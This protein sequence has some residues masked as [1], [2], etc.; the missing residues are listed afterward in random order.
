[1]NDKDQTSYEIITAAVH[2]RRPPRLPVQMASL[3]VADNAFLWQPMAMS[4]A[5]GAG[6]AFEP[7]APKADAWGCVWSQTEL[8]NMGQVTGHP[9]ERGVP[10]NL[11]GTP[12][13][14]YNR[15]I[16]YQDMEAPIARAEQAGKYIQAG[17]F[18]V[19]F[20]R[21]HSM[22]GFE[23]AML[24]LG[25]PDSR[26]D[27]QRLAAF[28]ADQH[29]IYIDNLDRRF[30]GR[31]HAVCM[32]D[33]FGTQ[34]AAYVSA[35]FWMDFFYPHYK[36][37]FDRMHAA[38]YDV[39]VHS[40]GKV[41]EIV[42]C[43]IQAGADVVN[44]QQ[45]RALGIEDMGR[46][47]R[48]RIA[49]ESLCDI[50]ATLPSGDPARVAADAGDLMTHWAGIEGGFVLSDYGDA[51]AIGAP[52]DMKVRMYEEFSK[53]SEALYGQPLPSLDRR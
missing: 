36:R 23:N 20:E 28:I 31:I 30:P 50:Q 42:E 19:L 6:K 37:L 22:M 52:L 2:F 34:T 3:G 21:V 27:V 8:K 32:T 44:L 38:G 40:C 49:F 16:F 14:D 7:A 29:L 46:R 18:M 15:D 43:Y 41:N 35:G 24:G 39:W 47:Y 45:P 25:D 51:E 4:G 10:E 13:P 48:G 11:E 9:F 26:P 12:H 1:M 53:R 17:L 33:D 5:G